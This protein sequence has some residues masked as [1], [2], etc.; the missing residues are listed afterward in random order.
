MLASH[1][2]AVMTTNDPSVVVKPRVVVLLVQPLSDWGVL[3]IS[4]P[5]NAHGG[6]RLRID[7]LCRSMDIEEVRRIFKQRWAEWLGPLGDPPLQFY[8]HPDG[9]HLENT[10]TIESLCRQ[11]NVSRSQTRG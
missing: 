3:D 4:A 8:T 1:V 9:G 5:C 6:P 7:Q 10:T 2:P 11:A